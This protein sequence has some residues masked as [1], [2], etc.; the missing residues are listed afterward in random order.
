[1]RA[2][3]WALAAQAPAGYVA[4]ALIAALVAWAV[5]P[6]VPP[7]LSGLWLLA[8]LLVTASRALELR[9]ERAGDEELVSASLLRRHL[10]WTAC[11]GVLWGALPWL[12]WP[13]PALDHL[14]I[15]TLAILGLTAGASVAY[16]P[17]RGHFELFAI[18]AVA[19]LAANLLIDGRRSMLMAA[20][21]CPIYLA[22]MIFLARKRRQDAVAL[23]ATDIFLAS[24]H[25]AAAK[26]GADLQESLRELLAAGCQY[27]GLD[28]GIVSRVRGD[29]Y[30]IL[31]IHSVTGDAPFSPGDVLPLADTVCA[32]TLTAE[33]PVAY[34]RGEP[35]G[36][37]HPAYRDFAPAYIGRAIFVDGEPFGTV[38]FSDPRRARFRMTRHREDLIGLMAEW[39]G[40]ELGRRRMEETVIR[41]RQ[42][43]ELLTDSVPALISYLT[44]DHRYAYVN[45]EYERFFGRSRATFVGAPL[46]SVGG[47]ETYERLKP[48]LDRAMAGE[49]Q[50]FEFSPELPDGQTPTFSVHYVPDWSDDH[51]VRGCFA[52]LT[53][54]TGYKETESRLL[55][56]TRHDF[57]TGLLNRRAFL[58]SVAEV[59]GDYRK[60]PATDFVCYLDLDRFKQVNDRAGHEAGDEALRHVAT[61]LRSQL[62]SSDVL[63]R[64]GGDEFGLLLTGCSEDEARLLLEG[65]RAQMAESAFDWRGERFSLGVSI[66]AVAID[67][68]HHRVEDLLREADQ[69]CY[70]AKRAPE[71]G[72]VLQDS[73]G[74]GEQQALVS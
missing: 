74:A 21:F 58:A 12:L 55:E 10:A 46:R 59:L 32:Y 73:A 38:N 25:Y 29:E 35:E 53:E 3:A 63:A 13:Q 18:P 14:L 37:G 4:A 11:A 9:R 5:T 23:A 65:M 33:R 30:R 69:A 68:E 34:A 57:L 49:E 45:S 51:R 26:P 27:F 16:S 54:V 61:V 66:G 28:L 2:Q 8:V 19:S 72:V 40:S 7:W 71:T 52:L 64:I 17:I 36:R 48:Y 15:V 43:L 6:A 44:P 47:E 50:W 31:A 42:R 56:E 62:R 70:A 20:A 39:L 41:E 1:M 60:R 22:A 67:R 24:L